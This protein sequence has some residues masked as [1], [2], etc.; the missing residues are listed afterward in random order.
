MQMKTQAGDLG[1]LKTSNSIRRP[2]SSGQSPEITQTNYSAALADLPIVRQSAARGN[3][4]RP[5]VPVGTSVE[6][7][8]PSIA[9]LRDKRCVCAGID[10][11]G[12]S[13]MKFQQMCRSGAA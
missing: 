8:H 5:V 11:P 1:S 6:H 2:S 3:E 13:D 12:N 9:A 7:R 10:S 4:Y